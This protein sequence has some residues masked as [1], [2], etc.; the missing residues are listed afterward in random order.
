LS[1]FLESFLK[2]YEVEE[3]TLKIENKNFVFFL[4]KDLTP[5]IKE[6]ALS[7][8]PLW[9]KVWEGAI[10]LASYIYELDLDVPKSFLEIGAGIGVVGIIIA[11]LGHKITI[12]DYDEDALKFA[13][14]N[15]CKNLDS[16]KKESVT[17]KRC[18][19]KQPQLEGE[20][21]DYIVGSDILYREEDFD[22]IL[23]L[24]NTYLKPTGE[25]ILAE[26]I[27]KS[28]LMF[29]DKLSKE[30]EVKIRKRVLRSSDQQTPVILI[31]AKRVKT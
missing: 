7:E 11:S 1:N 27:R 25:V 12:T 29:L 15:A 10:V 14:A 18:D 26:G 17:V 23:R 16:E 19:W 31:R 21:Y 24:F 6:G 2:K 22:P 8:F 9:A 13:L 28:S 30:Y 5:F 4:P 3:K 20:R